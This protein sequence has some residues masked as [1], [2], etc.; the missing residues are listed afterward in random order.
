MNGEGAC[1]ARLPRLRSS[2]RGYDVVA[3]GLGRGRTVGNSAICASDGFIQDSTPHLLAHDWAEKRAGFSPKYS[4]R[5]I[6]S[7]GVHKLLVDL[8]TKQT[9]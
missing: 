4:T 8:G 9:V 6:P 2:R 5:Y 7:H 1:A 3:V